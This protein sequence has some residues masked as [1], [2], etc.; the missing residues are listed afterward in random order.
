[1]IILSSM[2]MSILILILR[3][4][5]RVSVPCRFRA[6][7]CDGKPKNSFR[8]LTLEAIIR[9]EHF[10]QWNSMRTFEPKQLTAYIY[11]WY[12]PVYV[13]ART[14]ASINM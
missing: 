11:V 14:Q 3:V 13:S 6:Q 8:L 7:I 4:N 9:I 10:D 1:M 12:T 2:S 5:L